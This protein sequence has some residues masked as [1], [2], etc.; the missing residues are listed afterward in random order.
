MR[1]ALEEA[2]HALSE[3]EPPFGAVLVN[4]DGIIS[5]R[6]HDTVR[7]L[8]DMTRHAETELVRAACDS[9]GP[10]LSGH[11]LYT[12]VEP[13]P[14]CFTAAW[15]AHVDGI[16]FGATMQEV[17]NITAGAQ[18]ELAVPATHMNELSGDPIKVTGGIMAEACLVLFNGGALSNV[19]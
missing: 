4:H 6:A 3:G 19:D 13:C 1:A 14:M 5:A 2:Q 10:D 11:T 15:L 8:G 9:L 17:S 7:K 16:V 18:R 12:T